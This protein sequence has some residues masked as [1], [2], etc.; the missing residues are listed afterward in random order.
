MVSACYSG[1]FIDPIKDKYT[2]VM[3]AA[4]HDR[5]S[6]GC[7]DENDFTYFGKAFFHDALPKAASF[8]EAFKKARLLIK[9]REAEEL[10]D[11]AGDDLGKIQ[12]SEPQIRQSALLEKHFK[13]WKSQLLATQDGVLNNKK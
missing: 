6:F 12:H 13:T 5:T 1:G 11:P 2:T 9:Q 8:E 3:T 4:R 7:A 10:A